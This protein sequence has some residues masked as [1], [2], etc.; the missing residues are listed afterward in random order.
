MIAK[1]PKVI[2][3]DT[4]FVERLM[5]LANRKTYY[6]NKYPDNLCYVHTDGRTS[7]DCVNLVKALLNGY[8]VYNLTIGY[9]QRDLSNTGDCTEAELICQCSDVDD[10]FK[11]LGS[12]PRILWMPGHVGVYLGKEIV[13]NGQIYNV[14]ECTASWERGILYS[15]VA[16]DGKRLRFK[17]GTM[18]GVWKKHGLPSK[19]VCESE[20]TIETPKVDYST[21]PVLKKG[22]RGNFV[23]ILQELLVKHGYNPNGIDGIFGNG[24]LKAVKQFQSEHKDVD[25]KPLVVDGYVGQKTWGALYS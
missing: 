13:R 21:Y 22:S 15:F 19:W 14:I 5:V 3:N 1:N 24:C 2:M 25:G 8:N 9:Y 16:Q 12:R 6:K 18:N 17:N 23:Y 10:D 20:G 11:A 7:A 4:Q